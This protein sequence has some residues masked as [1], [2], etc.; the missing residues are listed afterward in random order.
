[1]NPADTK[2]RVFD[3]GPLPWHPINVAN[4]RHQTL[5]VGLDWLA[6]PWP[7]G[8]TMDLGHGARLDVLGYF[9]H[10]LQQPFKPAT[11]L[12]PSS[13][14]ALSVEL[15]SPTT[16]ILAPAWLGFHAEQR[17]FRPGPGL[18]ELLARQLKPEQCTEF[19]NPP[20]PA[21]AGKNGTLVLGLSGQTFRMDVERLVGKEP[22]PLGKTGWSL[23]V[24][25]YMPNYRDSAST[26]PNDPGLALELSRAE[27]KIGL[28][29][30]ARQ[31][32]ELFPITAE[33][34]DIAESQAENRR[35]LDSLWTWYH[36]PDFRYGDPSLKAVLQLA[37]GTDGTI[38]Y[39]SF[40]SAK[41]GQL[42]FEK[43]GTTAQGSPRERIWAGMHWKFQVKRFLPHA[44]PG[45]HFTPVQR[46][47]GQEDME[48]RPVIRCRLTKGA[49]NH[50]F[51]LA[52]TD[53]DLTPIYLAGEEFLIG[54]N[55]SQVVLDFALRL[56]RAEQTTD[57]G[58]AL[59]ASQTSFVL[60]TDP[61][62]KPPGEGRMITL[63]EPL[64]HRGY[65]FYQ[66]GYKSL[67][68]DAQGKPISRSVLKV[69]HDPGLWLKYAG[70]CMVALGIAC[71]FFMKAYF[72]KRQ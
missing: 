39:R 52:K 21:Q 45:P 59:P 31:A 19:Q 24:K 72:F 20:T 44:V 16:G 46:R 60:I 10:A 1:M 33:R 7:R 64:T 36:P 70:S 17:T 63:N 37:P 55:T 51:W 27:S 13:F 50:E 56:L 14:P 32:G 66:M 28:A 12:D 53:D 49:I 2:V 25:Q 34:I 41:T 65:R 9:P 42:Q 71:M 40:S 54:F 22:E 47:V 68:P 67:G 69:Q 6:H 23:R 29:V 26:L 38:Y 62:Q 57:N 58:S 11:A 43:A 61:G 8:C 5:A 4:S 3:P 35:M 15:V 18:I 30:V 48:T